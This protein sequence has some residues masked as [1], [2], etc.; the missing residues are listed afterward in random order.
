[1]RFRKISSICAVAFLIL[2]SCKQS[3]VD[4][5]ST[6][7][8]TFSVDGKGFIRQVADNRTGVNYLA[9]EGA[10]PL[11]SLYDGKEYIMPTNLKVEGDNWILTFANQSEAVVSKEVKDGYIRLSLVSL[12]NRDGIDAIAWGPYA[13]KISQYI[14]ETVGV[15]RDTTFAVGVQALGI[16]TTEGRPHLGDD[17]TGGCY[18]DPLP[19]QEVPDDLKDKI[20]QQTYDINVNEEGD[21]PAYVRMIRGN[22]AVARPYGSDIQFF[23]RDWRKEKVIDYIGR[24]QTV[25]ALDQD[26]IGSSIALFAAPS[27]EAV[28]VIGKIEVGEGLPHPMMNGEWIKKRKLQNPAYMLYEG[29]SLDNALNYA[30]SCNFNLVHIGD[31]FK[32]WGHF[33]LHTSRFPEG[34][35]QIKAFTDKAKAR[36]IEIGVH[37]LTMFTSTHDPYVSPVPSDSLAISGSSVLTKEISATDKDIEIESPEFFTYLGE[38]HSAKIGTEIV[39]YREVTTEK[40][41]KLLDCTRGQFGTKPTAHQAGDKIDKLL[42]NCY[43]GLFPDIHLSD[44]FAK[45]LAEVCNETGVGLMDFD[46]YYGGSPTG[47]GLYG[48]SRFLKQ[49]FDDLDQKGIIS[50]GSSPFHY[51]WHIYSFMNWGEPWYDN[52]R[53][54]QVNYR[55]ENQRYFERNLMPGMLGWFKLE[56]T[57]RPEDIEWIQARSAAFDAGYLLRVDESIEQ[58]GFKSHLFEA[59]R[60]WQKVRNNHLLTAAQREKMKNPKNEFHLEKAGDNAWNLY[61]VTLKGDNVHKYRSVQTGEPLLSKFTFDN[62]YEKQPVQ[63]Y[64]TIKVGDEAGAQITNL[65]ILVEGCAPIQVQEILKAGDKLYCDGNSVYVCDEY[66]KPRKSFAV[67][68]TT[69]WGKGKNNVTV[70]CDFSSS[71]APS[72]EVEFKSL[73][74]KESITGR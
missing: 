28:D 16:N 37:T 61:E 23:A 57:Y 32:S 56:Q 20:G 4:E 54:S 3:Y 13:T 72:V 21:M 44:V 42:N 5:L 52:L 46:G 1:M 11:L 24:R 26:F 62:P 39:S 10:S 22:A 63:F 74:N 66:W 36:G 14:G 64:A 68:E 48:A 58:S 49:W 30:D 51:W 2:C 9:E 59:I 35:E 40:P 17:A 47:H 55:L 12:S 29:R 15:V 65:Q 45:R 43:S 69:A 33:D 53:Q 19:G 25:T 50:C 60:E 18:I 41:Y 27:S 7:Y 6:Q 67:S 38:T 71:K 8:A 31:I 73:G 34:A 70:Q